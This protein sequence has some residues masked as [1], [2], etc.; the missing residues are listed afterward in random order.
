MS[1]TS[2]LTSLFTYITNKYLEVEKSQNMVIINQPG[3]KRVLRVNH[4]KL[5]VISTRKEKVVLEK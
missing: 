3:R 5:R 4:I 2:L 1:I